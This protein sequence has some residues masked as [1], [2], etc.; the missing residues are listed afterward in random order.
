MSRLQLKG[1][2]NRLA[3]R[4]KIAKALAHPTRIRMADALEGGERSVR[5]LT[6]LVGSDQSTIS[7]HLS[8]LKQAGLVANRRAGTLTYYRLRV[9]GLGHFWKSV[10]RVLNETYETP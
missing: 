9:R 6:E 4:A 5:Q 7:R 10:D 3:A 2:A 8:V 1:T